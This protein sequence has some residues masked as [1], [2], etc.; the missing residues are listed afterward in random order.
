METTIIS[1]NDLTRYL[2]VTLLLLSVIGLEY[3][4]VDLETYGIAGVSSFPFI[5][6]ILTRVYKGCTKTPAPGEEMP[7][8][9]PTG[10]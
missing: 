5:V 6:A 10:D 4:E 8:L 3:A 2:N 1:L 9:D 7:D